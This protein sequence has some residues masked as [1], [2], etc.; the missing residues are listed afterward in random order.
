MSTAADVELRLAVDG[1]RRACRLLLAEAVRRHELGEMWGAWETSG[2]EAP[3]LVGALSVQPVVHADGGREAAVWGRVVR[4]H[5]RRGIGARLFAVACDESRRLGVATL[6][7]VAAADDDSTDVAFLAT[8]GFAIAETLS[9]FEVATASIHAD[10]EPLAKRMTERGMIPAEA[11]MVPLREAPLRAVAR[12]HAAHLGG[13][14]ASVLDSIAERLARDDADDH[15]VLMIGDQVHGL[16]LGNTV[17]GVTT[18]D[19]EVLSQ[20]C[21]VSGLGS[22]WASAFM[23]GERLEWGLSRGSRITRFSC[24][25]GNRPT[26]RLAQRLRAQPIREEI[27]FRLELDS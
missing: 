27:V 7:I 5:R 18:I 4:T 2:G 24:T 13:T 25:S 26:R 1:K 12:L 9:T 22:G 11:R 23:L 3:R 16:L 21:R 15:A 14:E 20:T 17:D 19:A 6:R 10:L 8:R